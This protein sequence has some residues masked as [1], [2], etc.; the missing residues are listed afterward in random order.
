LK[1]LA[2]SGGGKIQY[3]L[4]VVPERSHTGGGDAVVEKVEFC[5][6]KHAL[7]QVEGQPVGI[8]DGEQCLQVL[9]VLLL[10]VLYTPWS[11][12]KEKM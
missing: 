2:V 10:G 9:L 1:C 8:E 7:L 6:N 5:D 12:K 3:H 11:S 4:D